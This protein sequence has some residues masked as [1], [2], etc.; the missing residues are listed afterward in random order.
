[1]QEIFM[2]NYATLF[3]NIGS[4]GGATPLGGAIILPKGQPYIEF[5]NGEAYLEENSYLPYTTDKFSKDLPD[6]YKICAT[7]RIPPNVTETLSFLEVSNTHAFIFDVRNSMWVSSDYGESWVKK[8]SI[9]NSA[10]IYEVCV[11]PNNHIYVLTNNSLYYSNN[12][13]DSWQSINTGVNINYF[14]KATM[15]FHDGALYFLNISSNRK[16]VGNS[17]TYINNPSTAFPNEKLTCTVFN[18]QIIVSSTTQERSAYVY[19][20]SNNKWTIYSQPLKYAVATNHG[21]FFISDGVLKH[22][23]DITSDRASLGVFP[24]H[25]ASRINPTKS[26]IWAHGFDL[27]D[28]PYDSTSLYYGVLITSGSLTKKRYL[29]QFNNIPP[30]IWGPYSSGGILQVKEIGNK[31][32]V[33]S[34][35]STGFLLD[36]PENILTPGS[37]IA[38][39]KAFSVYIR[40]K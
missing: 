12:L 15:C 14:S 30:N 32:I 10:A 38:G 29:T 24:T 19:N 37:I 21:L 35:R 5:P 22:A 1:M 27:G 11:T 33:R 16:I 39:N 28:V 2:S 4:S 34:Y 20:L 3:G 13:G 26:G 17:S 25:S 7:P 9:P 6:L 40:V 8:T 23:F 18:G 31:K 36:S